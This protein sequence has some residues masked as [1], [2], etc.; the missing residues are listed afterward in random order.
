MSEGE[1]REG[2]RKEREHGERESGNRCIY[3]LKWRGGG[4]KEIEIRERKR[5][6]I[7]SIPPREL[8]KI[9]SSSVSPLCTAHECI[10]SDFIAYSEKY[11]FK[12]SLKIQ[13]KITKTVRNKKNM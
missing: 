13:V 11:L 5:E 7:E 12:V 2:G 8:T 3:L 10:L 6:G 9:F 1:K 4:R